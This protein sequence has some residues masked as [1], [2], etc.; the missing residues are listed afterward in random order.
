MV[1]AVDWNDKI[2]GYEITRDGTVCGRRTKRPMVGRVT[3]GYRVVTIYT[4]DGRKVNRAIHR[5]VAKKYIPLPPDIRPED[6][7]VN[8]KDGNKLNNRVEN[9][10]WVTARENLAHAGRTKLRKTA[11]HPVAVRL[12]DQD[13]G[14]TIDFESCADAARYL[15]CNQGV[16]QERHYAAAKYFRHGERPHYNG[17]YLEYTEW[18]PTKE[19]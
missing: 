18:D 12:T 14:T 3:K 17:Y 13:N 2:S 11:I 7:Q 5:L 1:K 6:A 19:K 16:I 8:H 10:E 9:L 15:G 4:D